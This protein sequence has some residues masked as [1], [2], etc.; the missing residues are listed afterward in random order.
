MKKLILP[1]YTKKNEPNAS[2]KYYILFGIGQ[3]LEFRSK[4][5]AED[6][7]RKISSYIV[8]SIRVI[9]TVQKE[10]YAVYLEHYFKMNSADCL[11][12]GSKLDEY[13]PRL[14]FFHSYQSRGDA[15]IRF[16]S[17][18]TLLNI[19]EDS[20]R[21]LK[22]ALKRYKDYNT[23]SRLNGYLQLITMVYDRLSDLKRG[24]LSTTYK[25]SSLELVFK[26]DDS[27]EQE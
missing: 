2:H 10:L 14:R 13:V 21:L 24:D 5:K 12:C 15:S 4:R 27:A 9:N 11:R 3:R 16:S 22:M 20:I 23:I 7:A 18:Y 19:C 6:Y 8:D 25:S 1:I 17:V 26:K